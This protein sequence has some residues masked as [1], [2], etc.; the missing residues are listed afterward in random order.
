MGHDGA[1][2]RKRVTVHGV[3]QGVGFRYAARARA[4]ELGISGWIR[5]RA[6]GAVEAEIQ[7]PPDALQ[8]MLTWMARGPRGARVD[9][10]ET[11]AASPDDGSGFQIRPTS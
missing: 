8:E 4:G 9:A 7:G 6:D 10:L 3:V 2:E 11:T 1:V 5:N